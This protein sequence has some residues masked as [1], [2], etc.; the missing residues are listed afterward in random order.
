ME[1]GTIC[2]RET[3]IASRHQS[4]HEASLLMQRYNVGSLVVV[5]TDAKGNKPVGIVTDRD[6]VLKVVVAELN[7]QEL[8]L[9]DVMSAKLLVAHE[10]DDVYNTLQKMRG[11]VVRRV[12][13]VDDEGYLKGIL[14][15]DDILEFFSK[16]I[17]DIISLF[18]KEQAK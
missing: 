14:T 5:V 13:V 18:K 16:E 7:I 1:A 11:K 4:V 17:G 6:I 3:I 9:E 2:T 10:K 8:K 15:V 12:P